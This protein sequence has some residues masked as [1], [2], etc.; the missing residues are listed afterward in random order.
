MIMADKRQ[1]LA[2]KEAMLRDCKELLLT[3]PSHE[4]L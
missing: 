3:T 4:Q 1:V 2:R